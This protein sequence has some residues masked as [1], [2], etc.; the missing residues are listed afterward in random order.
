MLGNTNSYMFRPLLAHH[1]GAH[2]CIKQLLIDVCICFRQ[3]F[4]DFLEVVKLS[5]LLGN[6]LTQI[7]AP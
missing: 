5:C 4:F 6:C 7:C 3:L 1:Q 2:D